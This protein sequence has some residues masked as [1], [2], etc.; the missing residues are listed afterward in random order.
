MFNWQ[1][2]LM[3]FVLNSFSFSKMDKTSKQMLADESDQ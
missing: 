2:L 3:H 1:L